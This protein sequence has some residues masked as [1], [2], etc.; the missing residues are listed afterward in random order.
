MASFELYDLERL[1][2][3]VSKGGDVFYSEEMTVKTRFGDYE[4]KAAVFNSKSYNEFISKIVAAVSTMIVKVGVRKTKEYPSMQIHQVEIA[5]AVDGFIRRR[6]F[7]AEFDPFEGNNWR[8][9]MLSQTG[10][11]EH[12][13]REISRVIYELQNS[14][15]VSEAKVLKKYFSEI[16]TLR[17]REQYCLDIT[18]TIYE[19]QSYPSNKGGFEKAFM[20]YCDTDTDVVAFIKVNEHY[21]DFA[22]I[23]YVR[24]DGMLAPYSPDFIVKTEDKIYIVETKGEDRLSTDNVKIKRAA[25]LDWVERVNRLKPED[26]MGAEWEYIL[27][28]ENTFYSMSAKGASVSEILTYS[29]LTK[30]VVQG[31]LF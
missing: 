12:I 16:P 27:L 15:D 31:T 22:K 17:M 8:V 11:V 10:I 19:K 5:K 18:K 25:T 4:V 30:N 13:V 7:K 21:H 23:N 28:G 29:K 20:G 26:R 3:M 14:I 1:K 6:L 2:K 24:A 9:L